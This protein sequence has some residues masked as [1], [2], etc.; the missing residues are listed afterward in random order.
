MLIAAMAVA[1]EAAAPGPLELAEALQ[2]KIDAIRDFSTDFVHVY[3]GGVLKKQ[4]TERGHLLV[5]KPGRM[6]WE[7]YSPEPKT[8]VSDGSKLYSYVPA[9]KQVVVSPIPPEDEATTP[10]LFLAGKGSLTRDFTPSLADLPAGMTPGSRTLKLVPKSSQRDYDWLILVVDPT[11]LG[12]RGLVTVDGQG[13]KSS[14]SFSNMKENLGLSEKDFAFKI[15]RGVDVVS[16]T[17]RF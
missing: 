15:P 1:S 11:T 7:Y 6:R 12:I 2:K 17:S 8:F 13:G 4:V 14:F 5:K 16:T 10:S 3:E 9:D